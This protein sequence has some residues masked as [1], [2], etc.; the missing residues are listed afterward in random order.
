MAEHFWLSQRAIRLQ[1]L[2][3][4]RDLPYCHEPKELALYLRYQ[5]THDRSFHKCLSDLL[6]LRA[7]QRKAEAGFVS[8][9][10]KAAAETRKQELHNVRI[11]LLKVK[12]REQSAKLGVK[13][14]PDR[15][16]NALPN[17]PNFQKAPGSAATAAYAPAL[18][19]PQL[20]DAA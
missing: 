15:T 13:Y 20:P 1:D 10:H 6:K 7:E 4:H 18:I 14:A 5:T 16:P 19:T 17:E 8:Q 2:S 12:E 9:Q 11:T 3:F